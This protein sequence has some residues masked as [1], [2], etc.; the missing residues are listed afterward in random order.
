MQYTLKHILRFIEIGVRRYKQYI[1]VPQQCKTIRCVI[2]EYHIACIDILKKLSRD[3]F[4]RW[5]LVLKNDIP[6]FT[7]ET[8][9]PADG[10]SESHW[11]IYGQ[12]LI[13]ALLAISES[14]AQR[15]IT[16]PS[17]AYFHWTRTFSC[18]VKQNRL[19]FHIEHEQYKPYKNIST[20]KQTCVLTYSYSPGLFLF[21]A[22]ILVPINQQCIS[23][24]L[25]H[26]M[27]S[28]NR[29]TRTFQW[30]Q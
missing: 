21:I 27:F 9:G 30:E 16:M 20:V 26:I 19:T 2:S 17:F 24:K 5:L 22:S 6:Q 7:S 15:L 23:G 18:A 8:S 14:A 13:D 29:Y 4:G 12:N 28:T 25:N 10:F 1:D 11:G 3:I